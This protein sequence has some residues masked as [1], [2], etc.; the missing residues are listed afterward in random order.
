MKSYSKHIVLIAMIAFFVGCRN[1]PIIVGIPE[2]ELDVKIFVTDINDRPIE[3]A[4]VRLGPPGLSRYIAD[5]SN[6]FGLTH[7]YSIPTVPSVPIEVDVRKPAYVPSIDTLYTSKSQSK[8]IHVRLEDDSGFLAGRLSFSVQDTAGKPIPGAKLY[9]T[10]YPGPSWSSKWLIITEC[11]SL[12]QIAD[13]SFIVDSSRNVI[14]A[15]FSKIGYQTL[16]DTI[17]IETRDLQEVLISL[18]SN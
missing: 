17:S 18:K 9:A 3:G 15:G 8:L 14:S 6:Q 2:S 4:E 11:D 5:T 16:V 7:E 13:R 10:W 12:G 1:E